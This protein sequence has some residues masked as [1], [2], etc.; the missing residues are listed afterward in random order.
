MWQLTEYDKVIFIDADLI[1]LQNMDEFFVYPQLSASRNDKYLF[2]SGIMVLEPSNCVF[3]QLMRK[4]FVLGSYNG[5]DQGFL[6]EFF[7]WWHRLPSRTNFLK[8]FKQRKGDKEHVIPGNINALHYL[9][10]K[11][12]TCYRDYDCNW[13]QKGHFIFASD[14][15]NERWW[16]VYDSMPGELKGYCALTERMD[17]RIRKGRG[18]AKNSNLTNGHWKIKIRDPRRLRDV[19]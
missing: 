6:N 11:P 2:N 12:W 18:M 14:P 1:V 15:A 8:I 4:S 9:G 13:D 19:E 5:G 3:E 7:T 16:E 17:L 10:Y